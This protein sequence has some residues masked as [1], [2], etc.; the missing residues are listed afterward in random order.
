VQNTQAFPDDKSKLSS[1]R[2]FFVSSKLEIFF[3]GNKKDTKLLK[4]FFLHFVF[5]LAYGKKTC[6]A[7]ETIFE[8]SIPVRDY[9]YTVTD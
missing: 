3:G 4:T 5:D 7:K 9:C 6:F 8:K 2:I 1:C